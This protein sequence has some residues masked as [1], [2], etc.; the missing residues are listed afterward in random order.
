V[1][2]VRRVQ[3]RVALVLDGAGVLLG[4]LRRSALDADRDATAEALKE[5]AST[6]RVDAARRRCASARSAARSAP[7]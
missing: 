3:R 5:P 2:H 7:L 4:R 1:V 6:V